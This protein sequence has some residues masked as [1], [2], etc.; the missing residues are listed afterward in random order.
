M[1]EVT[2]GLERDSCDLSCSRTELYSVA[3]AVNSVN[4]MNP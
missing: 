1:E 3:V 2:K 4:H